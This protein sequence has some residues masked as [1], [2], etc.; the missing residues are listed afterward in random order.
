MDSIRNRE[1]RV[2]RHLK[3]LGLRL[4]KSHRDGTYTVV[5]I[6]TDGLIFSDCTLEQVEKEYGLQVRVIGEAHYA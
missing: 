1:Q 6:S 4:R 3:K 5:G 2:R